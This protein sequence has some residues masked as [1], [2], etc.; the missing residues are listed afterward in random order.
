MLML[1]SGGHI[2][3]KAAG[4]SPTLGTD[5]G[6]CKGVSVPS[7]PKAL[8]TGLAQSQAGFLRRQTQTV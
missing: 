6:N 4:T 7:C 3:K 8:A 2:H 5:A 1:P